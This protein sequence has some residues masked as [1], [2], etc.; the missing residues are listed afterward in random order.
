MLALSEK[1]PRVAMPPSPAGAKQ[2]KSYDAKP[3]YAG[4]CPG[5]NLHT[6]QFV[7]YALDVATLP[8]VDTNSTVTAVETVAKQHALIFASLSGKSNG[9]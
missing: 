5:G 7:V 2:T 8:G 3:G 6:Y 1:I 9:K 4:P